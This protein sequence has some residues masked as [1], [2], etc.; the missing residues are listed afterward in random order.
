MQKAG[1]L[2]VSDEGVHEMQIIMEVIMC[3]LCHKPRKSEKL[4]L[5]EF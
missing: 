4:D 3:D 2:F 1:F 5:H